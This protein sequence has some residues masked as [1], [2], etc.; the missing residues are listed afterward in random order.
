MTSASVTFLT[1]VNEIEVSGD[2]SLVVFAVIADPGVRFLVGAG[3][4]VVVRI[5]LFGPLGSSTML[6]LCRYASDQLWKSGI[7]LPWTQVVSGRIVGGGGERCKDDL[8]RVW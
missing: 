1:S 5:V 4:F 6:V 7:L 3:G 2:S 8:P